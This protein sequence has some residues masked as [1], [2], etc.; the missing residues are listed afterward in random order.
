MN[1]AITTWIESLKWFDPY[2]NIDAVGAQFAWW[3]G[4]VFV[5]FLFGAFSTILRATRGAI[6]DVQL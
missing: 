4:G 6:S 2:T 3:F 5:A 1:P